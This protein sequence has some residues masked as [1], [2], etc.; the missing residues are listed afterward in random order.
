MRHAPGRQPCA[1][2]GVLASARSR[3][4]GVGAA[5]GIVAAPRR[6]GLSI[7]RW[8]KRLPFPPRRPL[9]RSE[10]LP[11]ALLLLA[12]ASVF[13]FGNDRSHFYRPGFGG[14]HDFISAQTLSLAANLSAEH[15]FALFHRESPLPGGGTEYDVYH[16]FP[17]GT[18]ALVG[19]A[20]LPFGE[21]FAARILAARTLMLTF[22]AASAVLAYLAV[23]RL[24]G[25]RWVALAATLLAFG[26][27]YQLYY[28]D[29]VSSEVASLFGVMLTFHGMAVFAQE[30]RFRQLLVKGCVAL[31]LGWHVAA[32]IAPFVVLGMAGEAVRARAGGAS[33]AAWARRALGAA[34]RSRYLWFG[35]ATALWCLL[36]LGWN[37]ASEYLALGG[38]VPLSDLPSF[39]S[40]LRRAG[41]DDAILS[42]SAVYVEWNAFLREQIFRITVASTPFALLSALGL[43]TATTLWPRDPWLVATGA[44]LFGASLA[45]LTFLPHRTPAAALLLSGWIWALA[46]RASNALH[47]FEALF[48]VGVPLLLAAPL[49]LGLRRL[50]WRA[51]APPGVAFAA[52]LAFVLSAAQM[53]RVGHDAEAAAFQ[54][55]ATAD[56]R[57]IRE[58]ATGRSVVVGEIDP[59]FSIYR[60]RDFYLA[61][62]LVRRGIVG[63]EGD[64]RWSSTYDL[65]ILPSDPGGS[66]TP[67][68]GRLF[69]YRAS[70]LADI[71]DAALAS[72]PVVRSGFDVHHEGRTLT[73]VRD[74]CDDYDAEAP[75]F[76]RVVPA[77]AADLP[78]EARADG[79]EDIGFRFADRGVR[80][81]GTCIARI[82]L[83]DY[84]ILGVET[85]QHDGLGGLVW[86]AAFPFGEGEFPLRAASWEDGSMAT[87]EPVLRS[88]FDVYA[89]GR[90]LTW[91]DDTCV[92][93]DTAARFFVHVV[94]SDAAALPEAAAARGYEPLS[95]ALTDRGVRLGG[96]CLTRFDLPD[97]DIRSVRTGQ[98]DAEGELWSGSFPWDAE[99]WLAR[100]EAITAADPA[101]RAAFGVRLEGRALVYLRGECGEEDAAARFFLHV[102][103]ADP[104]NLPEHRRALGFDNFDFG[105][106]DRGVRYDGKC[107]TTVSLPPYA[108]ASVRTGRLPVG[109]EVWAVEFALG[110]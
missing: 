36:V 80:L 38:E 46:F 105:F 90:T 28:A 56:F 42:S 106:G 84:G 60:I 73:W 34:V 45:G 70:A 3:V 72:E 107:L 18:Y 81:G 43:D 54:R 31:L 97:Y 7:E 82:G 9:H 35:A 49:L 8:R 89:E 23:A 15:R 1:R 77:N 55:T 52:M 24:T 50:P 19:V 47:E 83:P 87:G 25:H 12:L 4:P 96:L 99:A 10:A 57:A 66:L 13:A 101:P 62:S 27:Y 32:L 30:G 76:L 37:L 93:E 85:G 103:P 104:A 5:R 94:P 61:G 74:P 14:H 26:S 75:F 69:L 59:L 22:F 64:W 6:Y 67:E 109:A 29:M 108:I 110:E 40:L 16:R 65:V 48:H 17:I 79:F 44:A 11:L 39:R 63:S 20:F 102:T 95:F 33:P 91:V 41:A 51:A 86:E 98:Y 68:N 53:G 21:D 71:R 100:W 58:I 88:H 78:P 2:G 92:E